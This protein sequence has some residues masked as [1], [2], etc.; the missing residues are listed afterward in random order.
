LPRGGFARKTCVQTRFLLGPAGSG[1]TFRCLEEIRAELQKSPEGSPLLLLAPKQATFQLER[2]LLAGTTL[3]GYTRLQILSFERLADF[4]LKQFP[5]PARMV[6]DEKGRLMVLRALLLEKQGELKLF[7]ATARLPG[8]AQQLSG[9]L[10][11]LQRHQLSP[12]RLYALAGQ[13]GSASLSLKLQDVALLLRAYLDWLREDNLQDVNCL[14]DEAAQALRRVSLTGG[15][16]PTALQFGGLW[17]DGFAEMTPQ[18]L[19]LVAALVP[20]CAVAT[21]AFCL[22]NLPPEKAS[23]L[24][25]WSVVGQTFQRCHQRLSEIS[26]G[27]VEVRL[28]AREACR[29]RFANSP[30]LAHLEARWADPQPAGADAMSPADSAAVRVV[31]CPNVEA[32]AVCIAREIL[33]FVRAGGRYREAAVL[34]RTLTGYD[35]VFQRVFRRYEIPLFLDQRASVS[36]HPLAELTRCALQIA[37]F[38][39]QPADW[40]GALKSGLV[41]AQE[42]EVDWLE[43]EALAHGW[44]GRAWLAPLT[45]AGDERR[46]REVERLRQKWVP[47][48]QGLCVRLEAQ[49]FQITGAG[50]A[51]EVRTLWAALAVADTLQAWSDTPLREHELPAIHH[52]VLEQMHEWLGNLERAFPDRTLTLRA[53]LPILEAGLSVL[54]VGVIPPALDQV[55]IGA[56]DRSRNPDLQVVF[57]PGM[58]E[59]IFPAIPAPGVLLTEVERASLEQQ[60][61]FL[62]P[63]L[64]QRLGHERFFGYI[65]CTRARRRVLLTCAT[66]NAKGDPLNPSPFIAHLQRLFPQLEREMFSP[67][68]NLAASAHPVE[69]ILPLIQ[70]EAS[71][72]PL[73]GLAAL[74]ALAPVLDRWRR[75]QAAQ[76]CRQ[77]PSSVTSRLYGT[78]LRVSVSALESFAACPFKFFAARGL[79]AGERKL[80]DADPRERG[81]FQHELLQEFHRAIAGAGKTWRELTP[82][83]A[84]ELAGRIGE[85]LIPRFRDGLFAAGGAE[86]FAAQCLIEGVQQLVAVLVGWARQYRFDPHAVEV[87]FGFADGLLPGWKLDLSDGHSLWLHGRIDRVDLFREGLE[88]KALAVVMDYK[89]SVSKLDPVKLQHGLQ[90]QLLA[91]LGW[92]RQL[93]DPQAGFAAAGLVPAGVFYIGL[94][95]PPGSGATRDD[96]RD[97]AGEAHGKGYQH[98][99]RFDADHL[100]L[101]DDRGVEKGD[102]FNY[103]KTKSG[104][105]YQNCSDPMSGA[106]FRRLLAGVEEQMRTIGRA[107]YAGDVSVAPFQKGPETACERCAYRALCRFDPWLDPYRRL[108]PAGPG[109][110][111]G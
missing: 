36:H 4:I 98:Q 6:L 55:L 85:E 83:E 41:P 72:F 110:E 74:P 32:E 27:Q 18:E 51:S 71:G 30:A 7:R 46:S 73:P 65:A 94:R 81:S 76:G 8:F 19:D 21:L 12:D 1:K 67:P 92:M 66:T 90:L 22:E 29:S 48:F 80:F 75:L 105:F 28:L 2:Q 44:K 89:S 35:E 25:I 82:A 54:T 17:L 60:N 34:L 79:R 52:T 96:A 62:G 15:S 56:I 70:R 9:L 10:R 109:K 64:H 37:A 102:Q 13:A 99:G 104:A 14:P 57:L 53:W 63:G 93:A 47:P 87:A 39:W 50:L 59:S 111:A 101:F 16:L 91:Y 106:D 95:S 49:N 43:N 68:S 100:E 20:G 31:A 38:D 40:F 5:Q 26:P 86:R 103:R 11:E 3:T 61:V 42:G 78:E 108:R 107:V 45:I 24:S 97:Q 88:G 58:N 33:Q 23:W 84:R 69:L 77:L